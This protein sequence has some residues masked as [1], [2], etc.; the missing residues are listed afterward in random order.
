[1]PSAPQRLLLF[2]AGGAVALS[3]ALPSRASDAPAK[4]PIDTDFAKLAAADMK[5]LPAHE[6]I[7]GALPGAW[8]DNSS[9]APTW[10]SYRR[11][12]E[13]GRGFLRMEVAKLTDGRAQLMHMI[14]DFGEAMLFR[15]E[16]TARSH[17]HS[18]AEVGIRLQPSPYTFLWS[19]DVSLSKD[20]R[21][22]RFEFRLRP[23][24]QPAGLWI[25]LGAAGS[26]DLAKVR[27]VRLTREM[28]IAELRARYPRGGPANLLRNTRLPLGLQSGWSLD[29]DSSDGDD[30]VIG[31]DAKVIGPSGAPAMSI[32]S[33]ET[34]H[35][36]TAP[37]GVPLACDR[38]VASL[39]ARGKGKLGL[40]VV[41]GRRV[42][43]G[44][45][46]V[47]LSPDKWQRLTV[48][49]VPDVLRKLYAL[50]LS[51]A[52]EIWIDALQVERGEQA[53]PYRTQMPCEVALAV[54]SPIRVQFDDAEAIVRYAV[55][56]EAA[57]AILKAKVVTPYGRAKALPDV[58]LGGGFLR[59]G[60]I[61]YDV[62]PNRP[63]GVFRVEA[64]VAGA[65]GKRISPYDELVV[66]RL[67]RPR[68]WMTDAPG[69]QFGTHTNST[70][71]HI[72][73]AKA[74]G[75]NWTRLHD[76]GTPYIGWYHLEGE[77]G[78][79]QFR[80]KEL[81]RY[82]KYGM[83][84]CGAFST[85]P[86]WA[87]HFS[88]EKPH[89]GYFDRFYQ[90]LDLADFANY[91]RTV[92]QRYKDGV[93]DT[94]DVWNEPWIHA[95]WGVDYDETKKDRDGYLT[96]PNAP[97][98]FARL[99]A[100]ACKAAKAVD[101]KATVLGVN[102]TSSRTGGSRNFGG[103]EW[104]RGV[105]AAGGLE[106]CDVI[107]Y[108]HYTGSPLGHPGDDVEQGFANATGP[109]VEK[110][111]RLPKC[112]WMT[113]G[114][115]SPRG[116]GDGFYHHTLPYPLTEDVVGAGDRL[117]RYLVSL[118]S[119]GVQ[120]IFLYSMHGHGYFGDRSW[121]VL[122]TGEGYLHPSAAAHSTVAW[123]LDEAKF[124]KRLAVCEGVTAYLFERGGRAVAVLSPMPDH[125]PYAPPRAAGVEVLDLF[126]NPVG[127]G[128]KLGR[129]LV[130]LHAAGTAAKLEKL[131]VK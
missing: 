70:T 73:M 78:K 86:K 114:S 130:Y 26:I 117:A 22:Y 23:P 75:V 119:R 50:R 107:V 29:R 91:V 47:E 92:T 21:D 128:E 83:K 59:E 84:I 17:T 89:N 126:G 16:L 45:N 44:K 14:P 10:V 109:V 37:F 64:W 124:V 30:V 2:V 27:L 5:P 33:G 18:T 80:D 31:P 6:R 63:Y 25:N 115:P 79:W 118:L 110:L 66:Y 106:H 8:R 74:V 56:G 65:A 12:A 53:G 94:W 28:L 19:R 9:W 46:N 54:D 104:S 11:I 125:A 129:H 55:T 42:G 36:T 60:T 71:R 120:K 43:G 76:A 32:R 7:T 88:H 34:F 100:T 77:K 57:G 99:V 112:V 61:R 4:P 35:L 41:G 93:I 131:L 116:L 67:R 96:S 98:D 122:V 51:G 90:P 82:R 39:Y 3:A 1:M 15:L 121:R 68:H 72:L 127:R 123:L 58:R 87:S 85:A 103:Y 97:A 81:K 20:W 95:W 105:V 108:H 52:G 102:S 40:S 38:H 62:F 101:P 69:S 24:R 13:Q 111:G 48:R 49:F 113:E